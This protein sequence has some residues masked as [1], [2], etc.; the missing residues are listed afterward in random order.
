VD[1]ERKN[2][3]TGVLIEGSPASFDI[4]LTRNRK[5]ALV[6]ICLS[7]EKKAMMVILNLLFFFE[8]FALESNSIGE[9]FPRLSPGENFQ[10]F[11]SADQ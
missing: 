3:W 4:L 1:L 9:L 11:F 7:L 2:N 5:A 6:P 8:H 10:R